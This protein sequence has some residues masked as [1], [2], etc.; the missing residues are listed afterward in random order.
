MYH[1]ITVEREYG[2]GAAMIAADSTFQRLVKVFW[3]GS[4][5]RSMHLDH[6]YVRSRSHGASGRAA[7]SRN[8][9]NVSLWCPHALGRL[10]HTSTAIRS[11]SWFSLEKL[12]EIRV[13]EQT[14][15]TIRVC[16]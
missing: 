1:L 15:A 12:T 5:A 11:H 14:T 13:T 8:K 3:R 10:V 4:C 16:H 9:E 2:S 6:H 7:I